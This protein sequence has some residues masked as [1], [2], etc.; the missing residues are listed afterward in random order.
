MNVIIRPLPGGATGFNNLRTAQG[1]HLVDVSGIGDGAIGTFQGPIAVVMFYKAHTMVAIELALSGA[2]ASA[3][4][5]A[6]A[7]AKLAASRL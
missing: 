5:K 2:D 1:S 7:L 3:N 4:N 6:I